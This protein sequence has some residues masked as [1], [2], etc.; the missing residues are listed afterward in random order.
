MIINASDVLVMFCPLACQVLS[1]SKFAFRNARL[2]IWLPMEILSVMHYGQEKF[3][4]HPH[5]R[6]C[7]S[8]DNNGDLGV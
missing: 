4:D 7:A 5:H 6:G 1:I 3:I 2:L 8:A